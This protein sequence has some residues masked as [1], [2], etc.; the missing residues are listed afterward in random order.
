MVRKIV[1]SLL[2]TRGSTEDFRHNLSLVMKTGNT[3]D[4]INVIRR[5]LSIVGLGYNLVP[6]IRLVKKSTAEIQSYF[7]AMCEPERTF[8]DF[9]CNLIKCVEIASYFLFGS[10]EIRDVRVD[11]WGDGC[12]IGGVETTRIAFRILTDK[13]KCQSSNAVFCFAAYRGKDSRFA[14]EQNL[15]PTLAGVQESG[16]LFNKT[17]EL[18]NRGVKLTYSGDSPFLIRLILGITNETSSPSRMPLHVTDPQYTPTTCDP[19]TGLRSDVAIPFRT[20]LPKSSLVYF[21]NVQSVCPDVTHMTTRCVEND[22]QKIAQKI[23]RE[24]YPHHDLAIRQ[25]EENLTRRDAKRPYFQF[26]VTHK[27]GSLIGTV[28]PVSL[29]GSNALA[30]IADKEELLDAKEGSI[31]DLFEGVWGAADIVL[32]SEESA[33]VQCVKV[34]RN[35]YPNL[36]DKDNPKQVGS[37]DKFISAYDACELLRH[38]LNQCVL[39]LRSEEFNCDTFKKWAET[40]YQTNVLIFGHAG[41]TPYKLKMMMFPQLVESGF[42][43]RPFDHMCEGLEKSNHHANRDF[44]T[45]TMRGGGKIYHKDPLFLESSSSFMKF[46][47]MA[48]ELKERE[49]NPTNGTLDKTTLTVSKTNPISV[50][51]LLQSP[52]KAKKIQVPGPEYLEICRKEITIPKLAIGAKKNVLAGLRFCLLGR[53]GTWKRQTLTHDNVKQMVENMGGIVFDN[54]RAGVLMNTHSHLP[55]CFVIVKDE[56]DLIIGTGSTNEIKDLKPKQRRRSSS[57]TR[58]GEN[59]PSQHSNVAKRFAAGGVSSS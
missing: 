38:S 47:R 35:W 45:K 30:V 7:T 15:G 26:N 48:T 1:E 41:L 14:M 29:A 23:I 3:E 9:R 57:S 17:F 8:S 4:V 40:Y 28:G 18:S 55:N 2:E 24:K 10:N 58:D 36:F 44:Q 39:C 34:L 33:H 5:R 53:L 25:L 6:C 42:I 22:L 19:K 50:M 13:I 21:E 49:T 56:K 54:D 46:L 12:E 16:W 52:A 51:S 37:G 20:D 59:E 11:I 27:S 32:G 43:Q 31:G